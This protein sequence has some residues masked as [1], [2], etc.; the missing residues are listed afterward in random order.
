MYSMFKGWRRRKGH[1]R[2]AP[3]LRVS[4]IFRVSTFNARGDE[5]SLWMNTCTVHV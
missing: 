2:P 3:T 5:F 1:R 4:Y